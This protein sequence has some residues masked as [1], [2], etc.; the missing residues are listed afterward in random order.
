MGF[1]NFLKKKQS[2]LKKTNITPE[3]TTEPT[4]VIRKQQ[5]ISND[6]LK[7]LDKQNATYLTVRNDEIKRL[8]DAFNFNS[9]EGIDSIPVPCHEINGNS[10]TGKIEYY[11]R[12]Q[13]FYNHWNAGRT[14][15]ALACLRKAQELMFVSEI[16]WSRKDFLRL[17]IYLYEAGKNEEAEVQLQKINDFFEHQD[18]DQEVYSRTLD[19]A[20][21]LDTDLMEVYSYSSYCKECAKYVNRIYSIS[22]KDSRFPSLKEAREKCSHKL[23]CLSMSP[24]ILGASTPTF[25]CLDIISHSNRPFKDERNTEEIKR[26]DD[27]YVMIHQE[28]E[29]DA[30]QEERMIENAKTKIQDTQ[31]LLWLQENFP[32][33][34]PKSLSGFRRMRT[35]NSKNYQKLVSEAQKRGKTL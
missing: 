27:W 14:E 11:L 6:E 4:S 18:I 25:E 13:C 32:A 9:I 5:T 26:F 30:E 12:G 34:A 1:F 22:G 28:Q 31:T 10:V 3:H 17:V 2:L 15:L 16:K 33:I 21:S 35:T 8:H 24:F 29:L 23:R 7:S 20:R 19:N